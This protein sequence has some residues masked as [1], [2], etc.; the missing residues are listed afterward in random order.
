[1]SRLGHLVEIV[2]SLPPTPLR[3][4]GA[5]Q[6]SSA[7]EAIIDRAL[8]KQ[9]G[10]DGALS[11]REEE[12][13]EGLIRPIERIRA[14]EAAKEVRWEPSGSSRLLTVSSLCHRAHCDHRT[15]RCTTAG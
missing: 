1:M 13:V 10:T 5:P 6:L 11:P 8:P 15:T 12:A 9:K 3:G 14:A 7:I 4:T 2:R